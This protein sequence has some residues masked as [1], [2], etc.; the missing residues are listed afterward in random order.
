M[1]Q[2]AIPRQIAEMIRLERQSPGAAHWSEEQYQQLFRGENDSLE[3]LVL[4]AEEF[5]S[6]CSAIFGF[7]V[8]RRIAPDWELENIVVAPH[9]RGK[10]IGTR[11]LEALFRRASQTNS[12]SVFL[13]VRASNKTARSLYERLGFIET[14]RR[15]SYYINPLE[16]A[17]LYS[18]SLQSASLLS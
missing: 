16:D 15:K 18:K 6:K 13:E 11:L 8:A 17:I 2:N 9:F 14:A 1:I 10:G 5:D 12:E 7:L 4:T 3:R